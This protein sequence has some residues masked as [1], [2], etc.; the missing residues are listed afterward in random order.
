MRTCSI[1]LKF[2]NQLRAI[3]RRDVRVES[4]V[5]TMKIRAHKKQ[6]IAQSAQAL[7]NRRPGGRK[8]YPLKAL[9]R[10]SRKLRQSAADLKVFLDDERVTPPGWARM[11]WPDEAIQL[12][13]TGHVTEISLDHD[14][15]DD[16][17]GTG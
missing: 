1:P 17:R 16:A 3:V 12:L 13:E 14:L 2:K 15:G 11:Y 10:G 4:K 5:I 7:A 8:R 6:I 9:S